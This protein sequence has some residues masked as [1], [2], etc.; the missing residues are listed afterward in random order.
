MAHAGDLPVARMGHNVGDG[1]RL[2]ASGVRMAIGSREVRRLYVRLAVGLV[3]TTVA[4]AVLVGFLAWTLLPDPAGAT[5]LWWFVLWVM[6]L[7][8]VVV[9]ALAAPMLALFVVNIVFPFLGEGVMMAAV[10]AEDP[11]KA[12]A[13]AAAPGLGTASSAANSVRRLGYFVGVTL[14]CFGLG[15]IP[16]VGAVLGPVT[17]LWFTARLLTWELLDPYFE[18]RGLAYPAQRALVRRHRQV[19]FGFGLP[20]TLLLGLPVFGSLG[21]GLAQASVARLITQVLEPGEDCPGAAFG[22]VSGQASER[23]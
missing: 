8:A 2:A 10:R 11:D 14:F 3:L 17:Q 12:E 16:L 21:F 4:M 15:L 22:Q 9:A 19:M 1:M 13:L 6:R 20:W 7:A 18:R 5:A 23:P